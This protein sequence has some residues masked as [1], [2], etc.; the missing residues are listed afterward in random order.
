MP[1]HIWDQLSERSDSQIGFQ[2]LLG[3]VLVLGTFSPLVAGFLRVGFGENDEITHALA[4]GGGHK[5]E[6]FMIFGKI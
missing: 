6:C 5:P 4:K 1:L 3:G 2:E